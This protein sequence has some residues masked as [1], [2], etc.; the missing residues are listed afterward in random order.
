M[1]ISNTRVEKAPGGGAFV[2]G[3]VEPLYRYSSS[4]HV[5]VHVFIYDVKG[6]LLAEKADKISSD[7]LNRSRVNLIPMA[8]YIVS[9]PWFPSQ[10]AK[11]VVI[12]SSG[13][14]QP[15]KP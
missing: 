9:F 11:V 3:M 8:S 2:F 4:L 7:K 13:K 5:I 14:V 1:R 12:E 15:P 10:I 6:K